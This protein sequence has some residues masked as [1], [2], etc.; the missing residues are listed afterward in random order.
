VWPLF[1]PGVAFRHNKYL[2]QICFWFSL[3]SIFHFVMTVKCFT[4]ITSVW[5][6]RCW[7]LQFSAYKHIHF[8]KR[9]TWIL[10]WIFETT[11]KPHDLNVRALRFQRKHVVSL[12]NIV[13]S[14]LWAIL[15][16]L[17][18]YFLPA[19]ITTNIFVE[20]C[21]ANWGW[22]CLFQSWGCIQF[23]SNNTICR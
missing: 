13:F 23:T 6:L 20:T 4:P 5:I 18:T 12:G 1:G 11:S 16:N 9:P 8:G 3:P 2:E 21:F 15:Y 17:L 19:T 14:S 10:F 22:A 7:K